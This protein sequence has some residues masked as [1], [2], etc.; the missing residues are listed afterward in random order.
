MDFLSEEEAHEIYPDLFQLVG[1]YLNQDVFFEYETPVLAVEQYV[2]DVSTT[3][4]ERVI[5]EIGELLQTRDV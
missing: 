4:I 3:T 1:G 2:R 5:V